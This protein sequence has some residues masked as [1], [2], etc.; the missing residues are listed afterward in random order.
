MHYT[1]P[2]STDPYYNLAYEEYIL[3]HKR[4]G[5]WFMLWQ[6]A[7][8]IVVGMN[9]NPLEE[10]DADFVR[11]HSINV[12]RRMTGGG[13][14][15]HDLG[16]LNYSFITDAGDPERLSMER[17]TGAICGALGAMGIRAEASG[18]ND[19]IIQGKK[20]SGTAQRLLNGRL[21]LHGTLLFDSDLSMVAKA[22]RPS[23]EKFLSKSTKSV[24]SRVA[25][26]RDFLPEGMPIDKFKNRLLIALTADQFAYERL[27]SR[28]I[29]EVDRLSE[30]KYRTWN[31]NYG[32]SPPYSAT[33][34]RARFDGGTLEAYI[35]VEHGLIGSISFR[36]DF[37]ARL[38]LQPLE[39]ALIGRRFDYREVAD[40][41]AGFPLEEMFGGV[42]KDE[43]LDVLFS[44]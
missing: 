12:I 23:P 33:R 3:A 14:V 1:E 7:N 11:D 9:Q 38:P 28:E 4:E 26:I 6:N 43:I 41:L 24:Q 10:I 17:F 21:L 15:Y 8:T 5:D 19:I 29:D 20:I 27:I 42:T 35:A 34:K 37:M 44:R 40:L 32:A 18:R 31:W 25:N 16:N 22:L 39:A 2:D 36:G 13:A 30:T